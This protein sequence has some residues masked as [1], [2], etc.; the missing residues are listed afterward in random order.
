LAVNFAVRLKVDTKSG[1][2]QNENAILP[3]PITET[4]TYLKGPQL[5]FCATLA[6]L[7]ENWKGFKLI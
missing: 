3:F 6:L 2:I 5:P 7:S 1:G 4:K